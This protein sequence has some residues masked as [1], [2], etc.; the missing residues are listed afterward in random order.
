MLF[1]VAIPTWRKW[2]NLF[3]QVEGSCDENNDVVKSIIQLAY[4]LLAVHYF[5]RI[6]YLLSKCCDFQTSRP[7]RRPKV[8]IRVKVAQ[9]QKNNNDTITFLAFNTFHPLAKSNTESKTF[10]THFIILALNSVIRLWHAR[11]WKHICA[12]T[13]NREQHR[14]TN[15][16]LQGQRA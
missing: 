11:K 4:L 7:C 15:I 13:E 12:Q 16:F 2:E 9:V 6:H 1:C 3:F 14:L 10:A 8:H 5:A